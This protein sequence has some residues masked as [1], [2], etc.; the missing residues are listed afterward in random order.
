MAAIADGEAGVRM[1][2]TICGANAAQRNAIIQEGFQRMADLAVMDE[3]D[4]SDMMTNITRLRAQQGGVRIGAVITKKVKALVNWCK[5]QQRFG[6][7]LDANRFTNAVMDATVKRMAVDTIE[8]ETKPELPAKFDTHKWVS[9]VKKVEN[10]LWQTKG[11][12]DTPLIYVIRKP[13]DAAAAFESEEEERVYQTAQNGPAY[14]RDREKVFAILTQL[15]SGTPAWTWIS[16]HESSKNGKAAF[17]ALR[18]H[19]DGPGQVEKRLAYAYNILNN[20]HYRS[21]RQYN[22][23]SYVTKLSEAFEILRDN[24]VAKS[25]REKVDCLLNGIQSDNQVIVTA[26]TTVRMNT[27][28]RTSF[29]VAVDNLSELIGA[30]FANTSNNGKRPARNVSRME[31]GR[32]G[33]G[34][35]GGRRA[36]RGGRG[37]RGG[38]RG[39]KMHNGVDISDLTRNFTNEEWHKLSP[40]VV[41]QVRDAREAAKAANKKRNVAA[42]SAGTE[43]EAVVAPAEIAEESSTIASNGSGFGSGAYASSASK[44]SNRTTGRSS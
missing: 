16:S 27:G 6:L 14:K 11:R 28:M 33:R 7:D 35:R 12:N 21:E 4:I 8:D 44:R 26:K 41:Q 39:G 24:D 22:F 38:Y 9:W 3:R 1:A 17:E 37:G 31:S 42:I 5:E 34:G 32:G 36:G 20:T 13:R 29:Q 18:Q 10:Y 23:E 19:Y 40:E 25:E 43:V 15:L 2:L 30:T